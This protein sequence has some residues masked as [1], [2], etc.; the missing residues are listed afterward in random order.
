MLKRVDGS[1]REVEEPNSCALLKHHGE[2]LIKE[3][4]RHPLQHH[5]GFVT[6][7]M[8]K[9]VSGAI[10]QLDHRYFKPIQNRLVQNFFREGRLGCEV[11]AIDLVMAGFLKL[12]ELVFQFPNLLLKLALA[13][14][15]A[16]LWGEA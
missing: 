12:V 16:L 8:V 7:Q 2:G 10:I 15:A 14:E 6:L 9:R 11:E 13:P 4:V 1:I 3:G 5:K